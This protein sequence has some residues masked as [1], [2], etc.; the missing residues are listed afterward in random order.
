VKQ[1][2]S[3][4]AERLLDTDRDFVK[5]QEEKAAKEAVRAQEKALLDARK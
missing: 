2:E 1:S 3:H 5:Q 4:P